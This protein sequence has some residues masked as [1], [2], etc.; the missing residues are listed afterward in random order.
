M[1]RRL[2]I[3]RAIVEFVVVAICTLTFAF[4]ALGIFAALLKPG[5]AGSRDFVEYWAA[6][7]QLA[8]HANPYDS[9]AILQLENSAE[10]PAGIPA[11]V[12]ANPPSALLLVL[13]LGWLG[14]RAAELLWLL[15]LLAS[16][17]ASVWMVRSMEGRPKNLL[18][19]LAL[20]FAPALSC[21]LAGQV[22]IFILLG[23]VFFLRWHR[24]QPMLA[25]AS[26]WL[27]LLKPHL[28]LPFGAVL[29]VWIVLTRSYR[30]L[31]GTA[32]ALAVTSIVATLL[33][34]SVWTQYI[35][36]MKTA[37][38]DRLALPCLG[39][40]VRQHVYP[41]TLWVQLLP[42]AVGCAWATAYFLK[43]RHQWDWIEDGSLLVLVSV[44]VAPYSWFMDQAILIPA[45]LHGVYVARSRTLVAILAMLSAIL[46]ICAL[47]GVELH[48]TLY[49]WTAPAWLAWYMWAD[50]SSRAIDVGELALDA[51][52][53]A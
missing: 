46:E 41:H 31:A 50:Q 4:T 43:R 51:E 18:H 42:A 23:L 24:S 30:I 13:P 29:L 48:S 39:A 5:S 32:L 17:F 1:K 2:P 3:F 25:G 10:F 14:P 11:Q 47:Q 27:C 19:L 20:S 21:L 15:L 6:A 53:T 9:V 16:L 33:D 40:F 7:H 45:L 38:V 8:H 22:S 36:M 12:L 49:L 35:A 52:Q 26:L 34:P 37:R 44:W 28:F